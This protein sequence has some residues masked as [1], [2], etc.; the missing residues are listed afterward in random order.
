MSTNSKRVIYTDHSNTS[1]MAIIKSVRNCKPMTREEELACFASLRAGDRSACDKLIRHN[2]LF[3]VSLAKQY[4]YSGV[5]VE[6][7][8][9]AGTEGLLNAVNRFDPARGSKFLTYALSWIINCIHK[10]I[11][12]YRMIH[13][14]RS[15][16]ASFYIS[17]IDAT[18]KDEQN[19]SLADTLSE[20]TSWRSSCG[21]HAEDMKAIENLLRENLFGYDTDVIIDFARLYGM[22][23]YIPLVANKYNISTTEVRNIVSRSRKRLKLSR[24]FSRYIA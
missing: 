8:V 24:Q 9:M 3:V 6:D 11:K 4:Q 15:S 16:D 1:L 18:V 23:K 2:T 5:P 17:S 14:P 12:E 13:I 7:L 22:K 21:L 19:A 10:T 20:D